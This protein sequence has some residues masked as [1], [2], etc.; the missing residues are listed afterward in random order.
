MHERSQIG[1]HNA[2]IVEAFVHERFTDGKIES[3]GDVT[4]KFVAA[5][6]AKSYLAVAMMRMHQEGS[7]DL[8]A[9]VH[10]DLKTF[11]EA[12][13]GTGRLRIVNR[14]LA[15]VRML[16]RADDA[17]ITL[18]PISRRELLKLMVSE[19]DNIATLVLV[20]TVGR[21][22]LQQVLDFWGM[23][24]T[25][26]Y[27]PA[28]GRDNT[29]TAQDVS[30]FLHKLHL[31]SLVDINQAR[32]LKR[33][34]PQKTV[35]NGDVTPLSMHYMDGRTSQGDRSISN[36]IGYIEGPSKEHSFVVLTE[37]PA[38]KNGEATYIQELRIP[39]LIRQVAGFAI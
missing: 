38:V 37:G 15:I 31:G 13:Y 28:A 5:S 23:A 18:R 9:R 20:N 33:L 1:A 24:D 19:S 4:R 16:Q 39:E 22:N 25:S 32:R 11:K 14:P 3:K 30:M 36:K 21:E 29:T 27:N 34:M 8:D 17:P 35:H 6:I 2:P 7:L 26:V 10:I 12:D